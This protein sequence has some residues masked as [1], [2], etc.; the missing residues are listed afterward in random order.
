MNHAPK[1]PICIAVAPELRDRMD[2]AAER[3]VRSRSWLVSRAV[4]AFLESTETGH[5]PPSTG[6]GHS[7]EP[8]TLGAAL[9]QS[10]DRSSPIGIGQES[11]RRALVGSPVGALLP[12][13]AHATSADLATGGSAGFRSCADP[14][15]GEITS[16]Y[17]EPYSVSAA[18]QRAVDHDRT[19]EAERQAEQTATAIKESLLNL[20]KEKPHGD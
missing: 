1:V 5:P 11:E 19:A 14:A 15:G 10:V 17:L 2:V 9:Q 3:L 18:R 8:G 7:L 6:S 20:F 16:G 13:L 12:F 4:S